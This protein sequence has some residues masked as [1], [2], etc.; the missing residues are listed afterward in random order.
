MWH[1]YII[2]IDISIFFCIH[3]QLSSV[4]TFHLTFL[5]KGYEIRVI[6]PE[7]KLSI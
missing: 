1:E 2:N 6:P 4:M 7:R 3:C 5:D